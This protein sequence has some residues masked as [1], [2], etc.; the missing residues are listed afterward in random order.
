[1]PPEPERHGDDTVTAPCFCEKL[2]EITGRV[3]GACFDV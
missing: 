2:G 3:G 1:M